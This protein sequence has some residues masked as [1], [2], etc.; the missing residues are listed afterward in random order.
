[1]LNVEIFDPGDVD[2]AASVFHRDGFVCVKNP[3]SE[4][5][6]ALNKEGAERVMKE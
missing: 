3:L 1:M 5:Q 6:F 2:K 4:E